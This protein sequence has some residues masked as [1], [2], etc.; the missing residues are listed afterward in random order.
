MHEQNFTKENKSFKLLS[1]K[2]GFDCNLHTVVKLFLISGK[3]IKNC[4]GPNSCLQRIFF[5]FSSA[6]KQQECKI[7][8]TH[9]QLPF[10][11]KAS[12]FKDPSGKTNK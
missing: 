12:N 6:N 2:K 8:K 5:N 9:E 10:S 1:V 11:E 3:V 7:K 4:A